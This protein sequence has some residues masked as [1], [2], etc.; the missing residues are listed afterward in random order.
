MKSHRYPGGPFAD[1]RGAAARSRAIAA[2]VRTGLA[3]GETRERIDQ[4]IHAAE[5][6][7]PPHP[8]VRPGES[9]HGWIADPSKDPRWGI[10]TPGPDPV[11][12]LVL[13]CDKVPLTAAAP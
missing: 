6:E 7:E 3:L 12:V 13:V 4:R 2:A 8:V 1:L 10:R 5:Q 9:H 11:L